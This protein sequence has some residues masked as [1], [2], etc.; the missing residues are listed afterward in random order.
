[1][2]W[3]NLSIKIQMKVDS[4][5]HDTPMMPGMGFSRPAFGM[6]SEAPLFLSLVASD[7][8]AEAMESY[9]EE[10]MRERF[11][12]RQGDPSRMKVK[13]KT[14]GEGERDAEITTPPFP[15]GMG[16]MMPKIPTILMLSTEE[17]ASLGKPTIGDIIAITIDRES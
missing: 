7:E 6:P 11:Q 2:S 1:V 4:I 13:I 16:A 9:F 15:R 12:R 5:S 3:F 14:E 17:F 8:R 10:V